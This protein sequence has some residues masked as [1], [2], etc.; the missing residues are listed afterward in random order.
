MAT[1]HVSALAALLFSQGV[2][3]PR[4]I[5][6][7]I[8]RSALDLGPSG[9]DNQYGYGLIQARTAIFGLGAAR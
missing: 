2:T 3:N 5:E 8:R 7:A 1:A 6:A 9:R 4:A